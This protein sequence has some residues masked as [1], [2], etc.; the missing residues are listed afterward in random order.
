MLEKYFAIGIYLV[1]LTLITWLSARHKNVG[2]FLFAS[3]DVSW[4]NLSVSIFASTVSSYNVVLTITFAFIF[5][6]YILLVFLGALAAFVGI[7]LIVKKYKDIIQERGF[8]NI[9]DFFAHKFDSKTATILN[10]A[11]ILVLFIF[12]ILQFFIN[13]SIFYE[14]MGWNKYTSSIVIG[15]IVLVYTTIGGLKTEIYTD[16]FQGILMFL[17]VALVFMVDTS[18]ITS[19][20]IGKILADK[21]IIVSAIALAIAQ[22]LTLL[23]QPEMWQRVVAARSIKDLKKGFIVSWVLLTLF[24]IPLIIIGISARASN[25]IQ[26][27]SNLFYD[28]LATSAPVWF[29][30][31]LVVGLF[32]AFMSTL[33]SSLFAIA[34]QLGKYGFI[35][36]RGEHGK[37]NKREYDRSIA[38]NTRV[39]IVVVTILAM[40]A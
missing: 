25:T 8:N 35:V 18:V 10:L 33:D 4:K 26:D 37:K 17:I 1:L 15:G 36:K 20:T 27:P 39:S 6:P 40:I 3:H 32:A 22:F 21:K 19:Q 16:I 38:K 14:I 7:Y 34:S 13:T 2:D 12:I 28:I 5:G 9:I 23:I 24:I 30:P 11:F 29:L 31:I